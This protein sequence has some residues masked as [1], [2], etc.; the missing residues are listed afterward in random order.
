MTDSKKRT[1]TT[2][3]GSQVSVEGTT[4][5]VAVQGRVSEF[6]IGA[7]RVLGVHLTR[8]PPDLL[9]VRVALTD[10]GGLNIGRY[11]GADDAAGLASAIIG[12]AGPE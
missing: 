2:A 10:Q 6:N 4:L 8:H 3:R 5:T 1:W 12:A 7:G 11:S 9:L